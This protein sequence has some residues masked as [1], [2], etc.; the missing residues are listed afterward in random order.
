[1]IVAKAPAPGVPVD[2]LALPLEQDHEP[3]PQDQLVE[4]GTTAAARELGTAAGLDEVGVWEM[5]VGAMTDIEADELFLVLAGEATLEFLD[6]A[7]P[8]VEL[9]A[10]ILLRLTE[11]MQ[12]RWSVRSPLRKLYLAPTGD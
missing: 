4:P 5:S 9:R 8:T 10:G 2:L 1:M 6:P 12:T 11:G 7:L 3:V